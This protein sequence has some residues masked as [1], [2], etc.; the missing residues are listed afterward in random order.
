MKF[1]ILYFLS[2]CLLMLVTG[3]FWGTWF[4]LTRS[5]P[6]FSTEEFLHIGKVI[7]QNVAVPMRFLMP[8]CILFMLLALWFHPQKKPLQFYSGITSFV[9]IVVTLLITLL[10]LVPIDNEIRDWTAQTVPANFDAIRARWELFHSIR[11]FTS[12]S[13]FALFAY[14]KF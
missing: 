13:S 9:L 4:T 1:K 14:S 12:L 10:A 2:I 5:L 3:V 8:S 6:A 11:T 7:I